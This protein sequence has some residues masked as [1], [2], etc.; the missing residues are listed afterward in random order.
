MVNV[1]YIIVIGVQ[2]S[3]DVFLYFFFLILIITTIIM[4]IIRPYLA[5]I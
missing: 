1:K 3:N 5:T 2:C 4:N